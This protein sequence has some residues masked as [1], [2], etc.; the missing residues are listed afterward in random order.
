MNNFLSHFWFRH[1]AV[2]SWHGNLWT[3]D[4]VYVGVHIDFPFRKLC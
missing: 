3:L 2:V 1:L 4:L